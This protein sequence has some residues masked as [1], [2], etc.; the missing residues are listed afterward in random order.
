MKRVFSMNEVRQA[1]GE[2]RLV[3]LLL[4]TGQC[5]VCEAVEAKADGLLASHPAATGIS[6]Y[7]EDAPDAASEF[8][9]FAAPTVLLM[10]DGKEVY[11]ITRFVRFEELEH[12]LAQYEE[13]LA[14]E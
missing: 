14:G 13:A 8:M 10:A 12:K 7:L 4:K 11:R 6:V 5:G 9:A 3:L 1:I 2:N